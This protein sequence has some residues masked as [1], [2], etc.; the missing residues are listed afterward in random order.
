PWARPPRRRFSWNGCEPRAR[1]PRAGETV[2]SVRASGLE[3]VA[4]ADRRDH[5]VQARVLRM[6]ALFDEIFR[7]LLAR[8]DLDELRLL[9]GLV[10][11]KM[12]TQPALAV[13]NMQ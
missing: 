6:A 9:G 10:L 3:P 2:L 1:E 13:V 12:E 4:A 5:E 8:A 7:G 11:A